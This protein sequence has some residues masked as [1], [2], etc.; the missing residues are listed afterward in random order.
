MGA[1]GTAAWENDS[2][3]DWFGDLFDATGLASR[4]E[5]ALNRDP[6]DDPDVIRAA[7]FLLVQLGRVYIWPV[8]DLGR[9]LRL[10]IQKLETIRE[11][12]LFREAPGF[13]ASID[14]DL[15]VLLSRLPPPR[16]TP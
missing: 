16:T 15:A 1:W 10:A 6:N 8:H 12:E 14:A 5:E 7:A 9:H 4:V 13:V 3:A 2:G 11:L